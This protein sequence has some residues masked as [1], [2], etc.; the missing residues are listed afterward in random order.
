MTRMETPQNYLSVLLL[1]KSCYYPNG[2]VLRQMSREANLKRFG[3]SIPEDLLESFDKIVAKKGYVGR[4]EA[5]RDSMRLFI[6]KYQWELDQSIG[7]ASLNIVFQHKPKLMAELLK[8][9]HDAEA[10]VVSTMH[11]HITKTHCFEILTMK[12][13]AKGI[14]KLADRIAGLSGIEFSELFTFSMPG[15]ELDQGHTH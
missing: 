12:G 3:V 10:E 4:S 1:G 15:L 14:K 11:T 9:Q 5:I 7:F 6:S 13:T 2:L 8:S